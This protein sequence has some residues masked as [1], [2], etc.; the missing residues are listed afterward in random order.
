MRSAALSGKRAG[1][2][3]VSLL[4]NKNATN[5]KHPA[6]EGCR[7]PRSEVQF[8]KIICLVGKFSLG[9]SPVEVSEFSFS[10]YLSLNEQRNKQVHTHTQKGEKAGDCPTDHQQKNTPGQGIFPR[11]HGHLFD[12]KLVGV[13]V[14]L[15]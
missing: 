11:G 2:A 10:I 13:F 1:F 14:S 12:R 8:L 7:D 6:K 9:L 3:V 5:D 4:Y 15:I